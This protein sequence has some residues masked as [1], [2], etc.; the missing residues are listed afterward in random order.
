MSSKAIP[1]NSTVFLTGVAGLIGAAVAQELLKQGYKVRG[2]TRSITK[3]EPLQRRFD[4]EFGKDRFQLVQV[5]D[6]SKPGAYDAALKDVSGVIHVAGDVSF[7]T[8]F[9]QVVKSTIDGI[10]HLLNSAEKHLTIKRV[11]LTSSRVAIFNPNKGDNYKVDNNS[12]NDAIVK[13]A[14]DAPSDHPFKPVLVYAAAKTEGERAVWKWVKEK[15]PSFQVNT[16]LPDLVL[17]EIINTNSDG[18]TAGMV[19]KIVTDGDVSAVNPFV[20]APSFYVDVK[21]TARIHVAALV[22]PDVQ[23]ERLWALAGA[24]SLNEIFGILRSFPNNSKI[25]ADMQG[26]GEPTKIQVDNSRSTELLK[27]QGRPGWA[28]LKDTLWE[29]VQHL[30]IIKE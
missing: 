6:F 19:N 26:F 16:I 23:N 9:D 17:G 10:H 14:R 8:D 15:K 22:E 7:S 29:Q 18:S 1:Q 21:D 2:A 11:V 28:S 20:I 4:T 30:K 24:F 3:A 27:R 25:P 12:F 13:Q 5:E